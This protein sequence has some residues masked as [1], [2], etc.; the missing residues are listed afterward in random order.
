MTDI[1]LSTN[2]ALGDPLVQKVPQLAC[3]LSLGISYKKQ[4]L[5]NRIEVQKFSKFPEQ[6]I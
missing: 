3:I 5:D 4:F 2:R 1:F 6:F